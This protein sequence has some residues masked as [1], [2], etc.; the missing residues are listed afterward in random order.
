MQTL[1]AES[2]HEPTRALAG[3]A[4]GME[5]VARIIAAARPWLTDTGVLVIEIGHEREHVEA[6]FG[7]LDLSWLTTSGGDDSVFLIRAADLPD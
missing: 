4:D 5:V 1:P 3:G 7:G 2:R 6:S